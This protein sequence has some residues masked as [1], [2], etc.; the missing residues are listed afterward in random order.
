[1]GRRRKLAAQTL[2]MMNN[3]LL[4]AIRTIEPSIPADATPAQAW[5][6]IRPSNRHYLRGS[7]WQVLSCVRFGKSD[8]RQIKI[9]EWIWRQKYWAKGCGKKFPPKPIEVTQAALPQ[10]H[11]K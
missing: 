4:I 10:P 3:Q 5:V 11:T 2:K 6:A 9:A 8:A 7:F 1:M